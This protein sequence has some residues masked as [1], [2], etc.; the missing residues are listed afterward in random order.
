M[1]PSTEH[2]FAQFTELGARRFIR[3]WLLRRILGVV[4]TAQAHMPELVIS[5]AEDPERKKAQKRVQATSQEAVL[6]VSF[7]VSAGFFIYLR[8]IS[9]HDSFFVINSTFV[10][11]TRT[12]VVSTVLNQTP[13]VVCAARFAFCERLSSHQRKRLLS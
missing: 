4:A 9:A 7:P 10:A 3:L 8:L 11:T 6:S 2:K 13:P 5:N 12:A 1:L